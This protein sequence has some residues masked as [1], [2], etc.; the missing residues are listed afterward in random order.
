[1]FVSHCLKTCSS[2][3]DIIALYSGEAEFNGIVRVGSRGLG[4]VGLCRDFGLKFLLRVN[5]DSSAA[6]SIGSRRE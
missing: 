6:E 1:M 5:A 3:Q 2:T 4:M